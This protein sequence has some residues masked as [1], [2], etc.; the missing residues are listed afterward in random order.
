MRTLLVSAAAVSALGLAAC[1][2][3]GEGDA[4]SGDGETSELAVAGWGGKYSEATQQYL[5]DPF[6]EETGIETFIEDAPGTQIAGLQSQADTGKQLWDFVDTLPQDQAHYGYENGLIAELPA[7]VKAELEE[8]LLPG[9]VS[10]FGFTSASLGVVIV[11]NMDLVEVCPQNAAEFFDTERFPGTRTMPAEANESL[12]FSMIASGVPVEDIETTEI[13]PEVALDQL[14]LI[15][16]DITVFWDGGDMLVKTLQ[17][18][19]AAMGLVWSGRA[20]GLQGDGMNLEFVWQDGLYS[21]GYFVVAENSA[22]KEA[23]FDLMVSIAKNAQGLAD[24][25][26]AM[27]YSVS[28]PEALELI[29][30]ELRENI[31]DSHL[32]TL[33]R[34]NVEWFSQ[35]K[36]SIEDEW[37]EVVAG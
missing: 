28:N 33:A 27:N 5:L 10:D 22:N 32:D 34:F 29:D 2:P 11:C 31:P 8:T 3:S 12:T 15:R 24:F 20:L 7:D 21:P 16:D 13:D 18:E 36:S 26:E 35:N 9:S 19:E 1:A 17:N 23:A 6:T 25:A 30:P 14:N 4:G 37:R